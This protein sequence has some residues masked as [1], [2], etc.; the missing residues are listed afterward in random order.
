MLTLELTKQ[1]RK[2]YNRL[3]RRGAD[4]SKLNYVLK[5]LL[6][7][8][9]LEEKYQDHALKGDLQGFREC[10]VTPDWLLVYAIDKGKLILT[11]S[12]TGTH[13]DIFGK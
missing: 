7:E 11:A 13:S 8:E 5:K 4:F 9:Q 3:K 1:Y 6:N 2:D 12:Q 10:H